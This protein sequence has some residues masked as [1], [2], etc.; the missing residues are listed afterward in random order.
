MGPESLHDLSSLKQIT[1]S[2][3]EMHCPDLGFYYSTFF[4]FPGPVYREKSGSAKLQSPPIR[5]LISSSRHHLI[6]VVAEAKVILKPAPI[7]PANRSTSVESNRAA[8]GRRLVGA[9]VKR[10]MASCRRNYHTDRSARSLEDFRTCNRCLSVGS[11]LGSFPS[12][13]QD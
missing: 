8:I 12:P 13:V 2:S 4:L 11:Y 6:A 9:G 3:T 5:V 1:R 7:R 10:E